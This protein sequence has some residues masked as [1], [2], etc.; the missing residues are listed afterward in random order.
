MIGLVVVEDDPLFR[1]SVRDALQQC[2]DVVLRAEAVTLSEGLALLAGEPAQVLLV[3]LG[4]PDGSGIDLIRAAHQA[5]P[6]CAIMVATLFGDEERV[7]ASLEAG[8]TGYLLKDALATGIVSEIR[9]L[10]AG[11][12]PISPLI[13]RRLLRYFSPPAPPAPAIDLSSRELQVLEHITRGYSMAEIAEQLQVSPWTVQ[14]YVRRVY[15][16]LGVRSK[17]AAVDAAHR[18]GL[19]GP[20][21]RR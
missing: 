17:S 13:A 21:E 16:K 18:L 11:G 12:S 3:D 15:E 19:L 7:F 8:A 4:L 14:T 2:D 1:Q 9:N 6:G 5:W 10:H 20:G